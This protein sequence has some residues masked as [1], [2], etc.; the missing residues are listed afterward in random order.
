[1]SEFDKYSDVDPIGSK[2]GMYAKKYM[3][4]DPNASM[5]KQ[6][7]LLEYILTQYLYAKNMFNLVK[8]KKRK[9]YVDLEDMLFF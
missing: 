7:M 1:M 9:M 5:I 2:V 3:F 6:G 8:H 4:S